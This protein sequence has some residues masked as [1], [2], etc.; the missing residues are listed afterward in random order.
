[1]GIQAN[2]HGTFSQADI[3]LKNIGFKGILSLKHL[4]PVF[5]LAAGS[6]VVP[7]ISLAQSCSQVNR[8]V[9]N[10]ERNRDFRNLN[11]NIDMARTLSRDLN[12]VERAFV[13]A[14][15][16]RALN[17]GERLSRQCRTAARQITRGRRDLNTLEQRIASGNGLSQQRAQLIQQISSGNC[18]NQPGN[19]FEQLFDSLSSGTTID[20]G[21]TPTY[22]NTLRSVCVRKSDGY[23][24][25][26]SFS[27]VPDYLGNDKLACQ[28]QCPGADVDLYY[29]KNPGEEPKDMINLSG[30]AYVSLPNAFQYRNTYDISNSCKVQRETGKI[31]VIEV[32]GSSRTFLTLNEI[33]LP[34][35]LRDPRHVTQFEVAEVVHVPLPRRRP[36]PPGEDSLEVV[37]VLSAE[38]RVVELNG[39]VVRI[40]GPDTPYAQPAAIGI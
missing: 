39:R 33:S 27:T 16:Q 6:F 17:S 20:N 19:F 40:V 2:R 11:R 36:R 24:W 34:L 10:I 22:G 12:T 3:V 37:P 5:I 29:Y 1:M 8:T 15:C 26:I 14:G 23:Y 9:R 18:G 21:F 7:S 13:Q 25:P 4:L 32:A 35:P 31:E 38:L 30:Q 28:S